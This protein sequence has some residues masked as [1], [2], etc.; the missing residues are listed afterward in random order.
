VE[1]NTFLSRFLLEFITNPLRHGSLSNACWP[2]NED[3]VWIVANNNILKRVDI[4]T[5]FFVPVKDGFRAEGVLL[6]GCFHSKIASVVSNG[7][8]PKSTIC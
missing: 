8:S 2:K 7:L 6:S 1:W 3:I 5:N 4:Q